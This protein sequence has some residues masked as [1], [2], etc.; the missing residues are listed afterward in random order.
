MWFPQCLWKNQV[1]TGKCLLR[2]LCDLLIKVQQKT[3]RNITVQWIL[4]IARQFL[5]TTHNKIISKSECHDLSH[6]WDHF[7]NNAIVVTF[8]GTH[9]TSAWVYISSYVTISKFSDYILVHIAPKLLAAPSPPTP[10]AIISK[11]LTV[12]VCVLLPQ[13]SLNLRSGTYQEYLFQ[14]KCTIRMTSLI[15]DNKRE[16]KGNWSNQHSKYF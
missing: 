9:M 2:F 4:G 16:F 8:L 13:V 1:S 14:T 15:I 11:W 10:I 7:S 3:K 5:Q 12:W 6:I